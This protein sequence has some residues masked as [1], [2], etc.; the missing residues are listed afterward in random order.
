MF[1]LSMLALMLSLAA[2]FYLFWEGSQQ[3]ILQSSERL[4]DMASREVVDRVTGYL[5]EAPLAVV[6]FEKQVNHGLVDPGNINSVEAALLSLVLANDNVSE[7]SFTYARSAGFDREGNLQIR[8]PSI[9]EVT[10]L[11]SSEKQLLSERTWFD[12]RQFVSESHLMQSGRFRRP[13]V[14]RGTPSPDPASHPTF[15]TSTNR[16]FYGRLL[17][18]DL[19][20]LQLDE[21][22]PEPNRRVEVSVQKAIEDRRAQFAGV[23]RV[24]LLKGQI[25]RATHL[26]IAELNESDPHMVF[27]TDNQGRLVTGFGRTSHVIESEGDLRVAGDLPPPVATA[28]RQPVLR[29]VDHDHPVFATSFRAGES[30][31]LCTFRALPET[32]DWIAG[33]VVPRDFYL[34]PLL[35]IR[36]RILWV[37][38]VLIVA[39]IVIGSLI[40]QSVGRAHRMIVQETSRMNS[41]HFLP[42]RNSSRLRDVNDVLVSLE[43]AK[44][45]MRAMGKYVPVDL[46]RRLYREG[47]DPVLGGES[48]EVSVLFTDIKEFTPIAEQMS[49]DT[50]AEVLGRYLQVMAAMIQ[51]NQGTID[52]YI[53]D[54][55]MAFWNAPE[56][57]ADHATLACRAAWECRTALLELYRSPEWDGAPPFETRFGLHR[58]V[59]SVGNFGAPD[60]FNYT[61]IGDGVNLA[62]RLEGL[63]KHYGTSIIVSASI[64]AEAKNSFEFRQLDRVSVKGKTQG[65]TIY[66]LLGPRVPNQPRPVHILRYEQALEAYSR[67]EFEQALTLLATEKDD[68]PS[69]V[70]A[71]RCRFFIEHP[72]PDDWNR[73]QVFDAK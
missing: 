69:V 32:Q 39:I 34:A 67:A 14:G 29:L 37:T 43:K 11:R 56:E 73:I 68:P 57:I 62:S 21:N 49:P 44:T 26:H 53:G 23:V 20:W 19:H 40:L 33:I 24:G 3:T 42:S 7:A 60:R 30:V 54:A 55:V 59:A 48:I 6:T 5:N 17:W 4:R 27:L 16:D 72:P 65:I 66:E 15:R 51:G 10:V 1:A 38:F 2:L 52:K 22:L 13:A 63:N 45:A 25:D 64:E 12:G 9:G 47:K 28:L 46:V 71:D 8:K 35:R 58:C 70:L 18:T 31:Y 36:R 61:A 41:F 50:L